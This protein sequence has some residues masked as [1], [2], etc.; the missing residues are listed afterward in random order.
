MGGLAGSGHV[1]YNPPKISLTPA[2]G[3]PDSRNRSV[4]VPLAPSRM[5]GRDRAGSPIVQRPL[6]GSSRTSPSPRLSPGGV[7]FKAP[8][9]LMGSIGGSVRRISSIEH[10]AP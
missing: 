10:H 3:P 6:R 1:A 2:V 5:S 8:G 4:N 7:N 9:P